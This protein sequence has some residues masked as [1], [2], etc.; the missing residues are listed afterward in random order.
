MM[1]FMNFVNLSF[2]VNVTLNNKRKVSKIF[3]GHP[4]KAHKQAVQFLNCYI[5]I[6]LHSLA[7]IV[8]VSN[9]G[10]PLDR[11]LYQTVKGIATAKKVVKDGGAIIIASECIDGLGGHEEFRR[12]MHKAEN[13]EE[14]LKKI[15]EQE[16]INDQWQAQVLATILKKVK[17]IMVT[18]KTNHKMVKELMMTPA[19]TFEE[20]LDQ[21]KEM[22]PIE[23][24]KII[25]IPEGP[26]VIPYLT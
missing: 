3:A 8:I 24:P 7:D 18:G 23:K 15:R 10:Y 11:D 9:G 22:I 12:L 21:A 19:S 14:V 13:P 5:N 20:A 4:V 16:P 26:Y 6:K 25:A 1:E 2:I 17:V